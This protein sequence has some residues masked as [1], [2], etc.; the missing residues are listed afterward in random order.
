MFFGEPGLVLGCMGVWGWQI[1]ADLEHR[2]AESLVSTFPT[3][4]LSDLSVSPSI[5]EDVNV[6]ISGILRRR[7][8]FFLENFFAQS[9]SLESI[10]VL[11]IFSAVRIILC[12]E[13]FYTISNLFNARLHIKSP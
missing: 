1:A 7:D 8:R 6:V 3:L 13:E 12:T 4:S 5:R 11:P 9:F 2:L 10:T